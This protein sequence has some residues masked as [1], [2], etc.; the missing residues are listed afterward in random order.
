MIK[1]VFI[2]VLL[3][4]LPFAQ[5]LANSSKLSVNDL[6]SKKMWQ[7]NDLSAETKF[8]YK[9]GIAYCST[10]GIERKSDWRLPSQNDYH[11]II[12]RNRIPAIQPVFSH[13]ASGCYWTKDVDSKGDPIF[14]DFT[15]GYAK[16][17]S[18]SAVECYVRCIR[19]SQ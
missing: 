6:K 3:V 7:D 10:L 13:T 16:I 11:S 4:S 14:I 5:F 2:L 1:A 18:K 9:E 8:T 17:N 12:D 19:D 15:D